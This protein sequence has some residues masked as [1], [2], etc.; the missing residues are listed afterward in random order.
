MTPDSPA[1][2]A[3]PGQGGRWADTAAILNRAGDH[4]LVQRLADL[5]NGAPWESLDPI[6]TRVA[7]PATVVAGLVGLAA[8]GPVGPTVAVV[9]GHSLGEITAATW[10]GA[11]TGEAALELAV[12]RASLGHE[13]Q[14]ARP[15]A[16]AAIHRTPHADVELI[17]RELV[18]AHNGVLE[19]AVVN[20]PTQQVLSGDRS[21][22]ERAVD[23]LSKAGAV[24]RL[25]PIGGAFHCGLLSPAVPAFGGLVAEAV[26]AD[27]T[28]PV[29]CSTGGAATTRSELV[30]T[31]TRSLVLPVD[32]PN[33]RRTVEFFGV[34]RLI[35][36][37][38][39][40]TVTRL[41]SAWRELPTLL[42][43]GTR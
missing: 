34:D 4:P 36:A 43:G 21:L 8:T 35:D 19:V 22:V 28:V 30:T 15:G 17:R 1:C 16:M 40:D 20:G 10:A 5:F 39:G 18:A 12:A 9:L 11:M 13:A 25:L 7:Q 38:P 42:P 31:L 24:A 27:P 29:I 6:D 33:A 32:W 37:G 2:L 14:M 3:F 26:T 41:E 23:S